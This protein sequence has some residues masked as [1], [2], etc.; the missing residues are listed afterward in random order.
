MPLVLLDPLTAI[1]YGKVLFFLFKVFMLGVVPLILLLVLASWW[2][3][4]SKQPHNTD[5]G[6]GKWYLLALVL[7]MGFAV[8]ILAWGLAN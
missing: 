6:S 4:L 2:R 8:G 5:A 3:R 7:A 1:A